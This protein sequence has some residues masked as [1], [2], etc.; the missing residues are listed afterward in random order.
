MDEV[1]FALDL[2][3]CLLPRYRSVFLWI[4]VVV[5]LSLL[6]ANDDASVVSMAYSRAGRQATASYTCSAVDRSCSI[7]R[8][9]CFGMSETMIVLNME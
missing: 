5:D 6:A 9:L 1:G 2:L 8:T 4:D 7:S 3:L